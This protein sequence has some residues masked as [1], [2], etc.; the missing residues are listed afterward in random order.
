MLKVKKNAEIVCYKL[1]P[2]VFCNKEMSKNPKKLTKVDE[3]S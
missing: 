2:L 3:N 1:T